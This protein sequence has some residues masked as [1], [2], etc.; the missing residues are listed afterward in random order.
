MLQQRMSQ[1]S[2]GGAQTPF[3]H[4]PIEDRDLSDTGGTALF[5]E[6]PDILSWLHPC[7]LCIL[8]TDLIVGE[9]G[10]GRAPPI[11][12]TMSLIV[13]FSPEFVCYGQATALFR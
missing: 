7:H 12:Q 13:R 2:S 4:S 8:T 6:R 11:L 9:A 1:I 3:G 10:G 5:P